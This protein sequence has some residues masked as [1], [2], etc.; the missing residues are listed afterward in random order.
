MGLHLRFKYVCNT[1]MQ[2]IYPVQFLGKVQSET[3]FF[4]SF[5]NAQY[6][7]YLFLHIPG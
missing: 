5:F 2:Y 7:F 4:F 6:L 3:F 1:R